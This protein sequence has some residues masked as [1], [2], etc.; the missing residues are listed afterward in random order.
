ML[1]KFKNW[2]GIEGLKIELLI[3]E[4]IEKG[5]GFV[6]GRVVFNTKQ[7]QT[8]SGIR[9]QIFEK[10][11]RGRGK[12]VKVDEFEIGS[13]S[14]DQELEIKAF[15]ETHIDFALPFKLS[16]SSMDEFENKNIFSKGI[17]KA[18]KAIHQVKS[19]YKVVATAQ[20][21][22]TALDPFDEKW[23]EIQ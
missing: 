19:E 7:M 14:F 9:I 8:I 16:L 10:Y 23:I 20:V 21:K 13:I 2:L 18:A 5:S 1:N 4:T 17:V 15:Q 12:E 22:G 3:P 6:D 11:T